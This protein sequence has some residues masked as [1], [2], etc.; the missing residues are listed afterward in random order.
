MDLKIWYWF[1]ANILA[2]KF[3][4]FDA[5][6]SLFF[7]IFLRRSIASI[8][9]F[10]SFIQSL[11]KNIFSVCLW[12]IRFYHLLSEEKVISNFQCMMLYKQKNTFDTRLLWGKARFCEINT[13]LSRHISFFIVEINTGK[14]KLYCNIIN[15]L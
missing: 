8:Y 12:S 6:I 14:K 4:L 2:F 11:H 5:A 1:E 3:R 7:D 13:F 9:I 10:P 15:M